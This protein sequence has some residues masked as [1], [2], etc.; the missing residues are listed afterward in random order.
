MD[1]AWI[2]FV[3]TGV[4]SA[5]IQ[6]LGMEDALRLLQWALVQDP[7]R[8]DVD[9]G[10]GGLRKVRLAD[11]KRGKGKRGGARVHYLWLPTVARIYLVFVYAKGEQESLSREQK[12][13]LS[14]VV[15]QI[16]R[17]ANKTLRE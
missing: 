3:E 11:P 1:V 15:Q 5:R 16:K 14:N 2:E 7:E 6:R 10:T 9:A 17:E 8:G 13:A 4:F 12:R